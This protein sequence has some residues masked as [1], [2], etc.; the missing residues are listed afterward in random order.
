MFPPTVANLEWLGSY[1]DADDAL[2][3]AEALGIPSPILPR[4]RTDA[5]GN[6]TGIALPGDTDYDEVPLPE[7]VFR[8]FR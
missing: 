8:R 1:G 4:M 3:G 5:E 6:V 2:V 7:F